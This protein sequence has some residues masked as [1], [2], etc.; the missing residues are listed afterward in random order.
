MLPVGLAE[1]PEAA[2][3][4]VLPG[5]RHVDRAEAAMRR[6]VGRAEAGGPQAGQ[7]LALVAAGEEGELLRVARPHRRQPGDR[8]RQR[9]VPADLLEPAL[10]ALA[11]AEQRRAQPRRGEMVH[12]PGGALAAD[13]AA[14]D[15]VVGVAVDVADP[16]VHQVHPDAAAA[17]AHVA[18]GRHHLVGD[19]R[20]GVDP[21]ARAEVA[22]QPAAHAVAPPWLVA[23]MLAARPGNGNHNSCF[24]APAE[25]ARWQLGCGELAVGHASGRGGQAMSSERAGSPAPTPFPGGR[26]SSGAPCW[27]LPSPLRRS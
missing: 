1:L 14:I 24:A 27:P 12:D 3:D 6:P 15:R 23:R 22:L 10:A 11:D 21:L 5:G 18:G 9:L 16:A 2:A 19:R 8:E 20:R 17:G 13:H 4:R 7:R 25:S 26:C